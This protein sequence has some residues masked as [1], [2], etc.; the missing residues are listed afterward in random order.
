MNALSLACLGLHFIVIQFEKN[1]L[2]ISKV[3][4]RPKPFPGS[5]SPSFGQ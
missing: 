3:W 2:E 5:F 1:I 4:P